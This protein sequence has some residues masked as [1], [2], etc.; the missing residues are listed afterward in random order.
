M[1][2]GSNRRALDAVR[3]HAKTLGW[4]V[5]GFEFSVE[6]EARIAGMNA[7]IL[8]HSLV[9][10]PDRPCL[11]LQGGEMTVTVH[12]EGRGGPSQEVALA[13]ATVIDGLPNVAVAAFSTDGAD[14]PTDAAG[15][16]VNG[17]TMSNLR[18]M[19]LDVG[20]ALAEND[21]H[22]PLDGVGALIRTGPT[23]TNVNDVIAVM[24]YDSA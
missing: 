6:G 21:T 11:W 13:A 3:R 17:T 4:N 2:I 14:G 19:G 24:V 1:L 16:V 9:G 22:T 12:G 20:R 10:R 23:G 18:E 7:G 15:A 8:A 5:V